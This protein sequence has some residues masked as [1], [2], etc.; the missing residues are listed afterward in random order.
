M[1]RNFR[2]LHICHVQ[3]FEICPHDRFFL[4]G[5]RL[6]VRDKYQVWAGDVSHV[7]IF[8]LFTDSH[9]FV[10]KCCLCGSSTFSWVFFRLWD[11]Y[12]YCFWVGL[13][14]WAYC[15]V[16]KLNN[17]VQHFQYCLTRKRIAFEIFFKYRFLKWFYPVSPEEGSAGCEIQFW[18]RNI[19]F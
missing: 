5:H 15:S 14:G 1:W 4:H 9:T 11:F 6:C 7:A 17:V 12:F 18:Y 13:F 8:I 19:A 3:K 16:L 2:F 10:A